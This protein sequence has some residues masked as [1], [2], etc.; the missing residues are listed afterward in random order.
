MTAAFATWLFAATWKGT[1][2]IAFVL[3]IHRVMR[4]R[5]PSRWLCALLL[6]ALVRLLAPITPAAPFSIFN[7]VPT[8]VAGAPVLVVQDE[9]GPP[10]QAFKRT[11]EPPPPHPESA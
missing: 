11:A 4:N 2:L 1:L 3:V 7:L 6:L 9:A 8:S 5:I 10:V